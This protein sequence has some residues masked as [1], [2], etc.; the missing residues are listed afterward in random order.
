MKRI[1]W[2]FLKP[3]LKLDCVTQ[4]QG[5]LLQK[6][7]ISGLIL[8]LDNTLMLPEQCTVEPFIM[9]WLET[10]RQQG[11]QCLVLSNNKNRQYCDQAAQ[12]LNIP[13]IPLARKP[14]CDGFKAALKLLR[15]QPS[16]VAMVGDR[17]LTDVWV[18][19]KMQAI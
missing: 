18:G 4:I 14:D 13:V 5:S 3:T 16:Q 17:L 1:D 6:H 11:V 10:M 15:L 9:N 12:V 8:D 19:Q 7:G 2:L